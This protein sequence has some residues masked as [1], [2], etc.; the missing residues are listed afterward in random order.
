MTSAGPDGETPRERERPAPSLEE[1]TAR[2][3]A[4]K[5][6]A[7]LE[8]GSKRRKRGTSGG[9]GAGDDEQ[10]P[11]ASMGLAWRISSDLL[12]GVAVGG[13]AGW[14]LDQ[15]LGT[16]PILFVVFFFLGTAA[17]FR[18]VIR[19]VNDENARQT[20]KRGPDEKD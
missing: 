12:A 20:G 17:G 3:D 16:W 9:N 19:L 4:A 5:A 13:F 8:G 18:N 7:A 2:L 6:R 1:M 15:W 10:P 14:A 11:G